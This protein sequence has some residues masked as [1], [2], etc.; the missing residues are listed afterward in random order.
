MFA[1]SADKSLGVGNHTTSLKIQ[2]A[3]LILSVDQSTCYND[4]PIIHNTD[5]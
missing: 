3:N 5:S 2:L 1:I 4:V